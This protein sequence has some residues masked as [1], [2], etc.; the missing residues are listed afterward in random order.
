ME[1]IRGT[2][3]DVTYDRVALCPECKGNGGKESFGYI[4]CPKCNGSRSEL[5]RKK[6]F[7]YYKDCTKCNG[8]GRILKDICG[9]LNYIY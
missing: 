2:I 3:K 1:G 4:T 5:T 8:L 7:I 6:G 9:Y